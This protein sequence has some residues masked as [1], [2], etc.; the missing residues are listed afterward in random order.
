MNINVTGD[1]AVIEVYKYSNFEQVAEFS[2]R[3]GSIVHFADIV[4]EVIKY[5]H[6]LVGDR[7]KVGIEN[8]AIG[9]SV[10]DI[11]IQDEDFDYIPYLYKTRSKH[12][13]D[14]GITTGRN[15]DEMITYLYDYITHDP[16]LLYSSDLISQLSVIEKKSGGKI[17]AASGHHDDLFMA[18][19]F[20]AY[21]KKQCQLE[22]S[23]LINVDTE[24]YNE[25]RV[26]EIQSLL[27][28][29]QSPSATKSFITD[30][31]NINTEDDLDFDESLP[32]WYSHF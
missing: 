21:L 16:T 5:V 11:L 9:G 15:K 23:P 17:S 6:T 2:A 22:I 4:K 27:T 24:N 14:Y 30:F 26:N 12:K 7:I 25:M 20:C 8:N 32:F 3:L 18:S 29:N 13:E 31:S 28:I 1:F 19:A 10:V